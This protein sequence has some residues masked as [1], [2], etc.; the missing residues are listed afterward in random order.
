MQY[1]AEAG[2]S[3]QALELRALPGMFGTLVVRV[4]VAGASGKVTA[5][6]CA[7]QLPASASQ[8]QC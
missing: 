4:T 3:M 2:V 7:R 1:L 5:M 6:R 8:S